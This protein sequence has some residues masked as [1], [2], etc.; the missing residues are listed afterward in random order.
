ML[1]PICGVP[2]P[3]VGTMAAHLAEVHLVA[4][5]EAMRQAR[6]VAVEGACDE[7][8]ERTPG[9]SVRT[10]EAVPVPLSVRRRPARRR[11]GPRSVDAQGGGPTLSRRASA[12]AAHGQHVKETRAMETETGQQT[13]FCKKVG[14]G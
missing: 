10:R 2:Q 11:Q 5:S 4:P 3:T 1:C 13:F 8:D 14:H 12:V 6:A 7:T 9:E